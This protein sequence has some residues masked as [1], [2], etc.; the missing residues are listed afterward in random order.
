ME[1]D[2]S[3]TENNNFFHDLEEAKHFQS[4]LNSFKGYKFAIFLLIIYQ[5]AI[6]R[7]FFFFY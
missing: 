3:S 2:G 4:T 6:L 7:I 1:S 5:N